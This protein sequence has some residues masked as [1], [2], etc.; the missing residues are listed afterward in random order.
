MS[1]ES[2]PWPESR[3]TQN[4][5]FAV[6][7]VLLAVVALA[8]AEVVRM[9]GAYVVMITAVGSWVLIYG[10]LGR[11]GIWFAEPAVDDHEGGAEDDPQGDDEEA[12]GED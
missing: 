4:A 9:G 11:A 8:L 1:E 5:L 3:R 10:L 6:G 7:G 12:D 2:S